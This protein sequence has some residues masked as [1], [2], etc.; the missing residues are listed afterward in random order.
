M[1]RNIQTKVFKFILGYEASNVYTATRDGDTE[2]EY[3]HVLVDNVSVYLT[4]MPENLWDTAAFFAGV[5][6]AVCKCCGLRCEVSSHSK[7]DSGD[8]P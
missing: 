2:K 1:V 6:E 8:N 7:M 5:I 3:F 4:W